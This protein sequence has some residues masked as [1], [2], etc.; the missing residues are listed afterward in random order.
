MQLLRRVLTGAIADSGKEIR[1]FVDGPPV[2]ACDI[3]LV[4]AEFY[5]QHP[6]D[7]TEKQKTSARRQ[8]FNRSIRNSAAR[9]LVA[10]REID[11]IQLI[12]LCKP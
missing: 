9:G 7:G 2:R 6:A 1:P 8:A 4:R 5:R 12:W 3:E 11:G 10:T